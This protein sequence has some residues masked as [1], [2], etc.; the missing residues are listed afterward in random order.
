MKQVNTV[1]KEKIDETLVLSGCDKANK[2]YDELLDEV[3]KTGWYCD[4]TGVICESQF[5]SLFNKF[6]F[7]LIKRGWSQ[8]DLI[9]ELKDTVE[10]NKFAVEPQDKFI[11]NSMKKFR[12]SLR[13]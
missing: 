3:G 2:I 5:L 12:Q 6:A 11:V 1:L 10:R 4:E 9:E 8:Y 7:C 13:T